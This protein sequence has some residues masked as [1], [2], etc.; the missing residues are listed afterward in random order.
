MQGG[1]VAATKTNVEI[2]RATA[3]P[4]QGVAIQVESGCKVFG[5]F[6]NV[7]VLPQAETALSNIYMIIYKN[8]SNNIADTNIPNA[9]ATGI[10]PFRR[11]VFHT[12]MAMMSD[13]ADSIPITLFKGVLKIPE[14]F[15]T[16][17]EDDRVEIQL[18]APA[19]T[20][21]FCVECIYKEVR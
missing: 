12:E 7:Q 19:S 4:S 15:Q 3:S 16:M 9:N 1:I 10:D 8:P 20:V 2:I 11:Q 13:A 17:R 5:L 14:T 6:L 21:D 18:F